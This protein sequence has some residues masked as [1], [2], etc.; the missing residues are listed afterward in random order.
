MPDDEDLIRRCLRELG[1]AGARLDH[2]AT[3]PGADSGS[4]VFRLELDGAE[5][6]VLKVTTSPERDGARRELAFYTTLAGRLP[7]RT[8]ALLGAADTDELTC[9]LLE[10]ARTSPAAGAWSA[11][12]WLSLASQLGELHRPETLQHISDAEWLGRSGWPPADHVATTADA[13]RRQ[14]RDLGYG[15]LTDPLFDRLDD[16]AGALAALPECLLHGDCHVANLLLGESD[17]DL[18]WS[19]WQGTTIGHGPEDF[20]LLWGRANADS[21]RPPLKEMQATYARVRGIP[22]DDLLRRAMVA[23]QIRL[24]L[25]GWPTRLPHFGES[26][27]RRIVGHLAGLADQW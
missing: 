25:F 18:V 13:T 2:H 4:Q 3:L 11:D 19:D 7:I 9:L 17:A 27:Q 21:G 6:A 1:L 14:W 5:P 12:Q 26:R 8:P 10:A 22:N 15:D 16:L 20:A 23:G 24:A